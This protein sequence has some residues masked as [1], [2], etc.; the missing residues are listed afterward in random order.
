MAVDVTKT[1][2]HIFQLMHKLF[3]VKTKT[4]LKFPF[5]E[6]FSSDFFGITNIYTVKLS[7]ILLSSFTE[8]EKKR[9]LSIHCLTMHCILHQH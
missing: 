6:E 5:K 1:N 9:M 2:S 7:S 3:I 8:I 4:D